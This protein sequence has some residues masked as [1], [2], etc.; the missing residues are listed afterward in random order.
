MS[1]IS[2]VFLSNS[3]VLRVPVGSN[4]KFSTFSKTESSQK[5]SSLVECSHHDPRKIRNVRGCVPRQDDR[6]LIQNF[7]K[8]I[9]S[10]NDQIEKCDFNMIGI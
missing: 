1:S 9:I 8:K 6:Q 7:S 2:R 4:F 3:A 10:N 5:E